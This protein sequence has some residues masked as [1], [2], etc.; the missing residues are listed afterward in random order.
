MLSFVR[1]L[2]F[3]LLC[4]IVFVEAMPSMRPAKKAMRN[5]LVRFGKRADPIGSDDVFL[6]ESFGSVG[7]YEYAPERMSNRGGSPVLLY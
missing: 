3:A 1:T 7:P 6:G 4:S 5:S 2:I